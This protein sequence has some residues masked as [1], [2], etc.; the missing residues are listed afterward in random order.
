MVLYEDCEYPGTAGVRALQ[1]GGARARRPL[2]RA[3]V[4]AGVRA[5]DVGVSAAVRRTGC[6]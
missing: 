6:A 1:V 5:P 2:L 4:R 3:R